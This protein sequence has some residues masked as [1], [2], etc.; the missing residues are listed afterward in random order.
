M[1][2]TSSII[3]LSLVEIDRQILVFLLSLFLCLFCY[4]F[5]TLLPVDSFGDVI[6]LFNKR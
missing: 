3:L 1:V 5:V 2:W 6:E 4:L